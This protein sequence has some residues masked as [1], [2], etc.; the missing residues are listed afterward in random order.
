[1]AQVKGRLVRPFV[2]RYWLFVSGCLVDNVTSG[3][4]DGF[5]L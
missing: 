4:R 1:M 3:W 5:G 2:N